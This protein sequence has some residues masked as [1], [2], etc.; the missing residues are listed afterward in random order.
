MSYVYTFFINLFF[1]EKRE[2][3][4]KEDRLF[5][6][7]KLVLN[8]DIAT[9]QELMD[10]LQKED[11]YTTQATL[12]RDIKELN[13]IKLTHSNKTTKYV[14]YHDTFRDK[15]LYYR[16][17]KSLTNYVKTIT[18]VQFFVILLV[19]PTH[20]NIV[21]SLID[22]LKIPEIAGT[23]ASFDTCLIILKT[24]T[25]ARLLADC[26]SDIFKNQSEVT[27]EQALSQLF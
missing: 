15:S 17:E 12:S 8:H 23:I 16:L 4:K 11:I 5:A 7:K 3:M 21:A 1:L 19:V 2:I 6:I 27:F 20:P 26:F 24:E 9:Q 25:D 14:F 18:C 13:L 22:E 10:H